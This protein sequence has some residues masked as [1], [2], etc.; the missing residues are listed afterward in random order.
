MTL[1]V[2][3]IKSIFI[4]LLVLSGNTVLHGQCHKLQPLDLDKIQLEEKKRIAQGKLPRYAYPIEVAINPQTHGNWKQ[5]KNGHIEWQF[6]L[7]IPNAIAVNLGIT[8]FF[9]P[10]Q[11]TFNL[12]NPDN[13]SE[14]HTFST[15]DNETHRQLW[16]PNIS[17]NKL[18]LTI[19]LPESERQNLQFS[20]TKVNASFQAIAPAKIAG[21]C[22][23][24]VNCGPVD[25]W[26]IIQPY[27]DVIRSVGRIS[28]NGTTF[29][30]AV[31][32]NNTANDCRPF[33]MTGQHC[34]ISN[35][36]ASSIV[37]NWLYENSNCREIGTI[38]NGQPGDGTLDFIN[39]G[40]IFRAD[41]N[42]ADLTLFELD[43][44]VNP[45]ANTFFAGWNRTAVTPDS[46]CCIHHPQGQE[47]RI[48]FEFDD[49]FPTIWGSGDTLVENGNHILIPNWE[50][51]TTENGSS[52]AP[53][54]NKNQQVIGTLHGGIASCINQEGY[55]KFGRLYAAWNEAETPANSLS[56][57][58]DP[59][60]SNQ[61][62][63]EGK[64]N[65]ACGLYLFTLNNTQSICSQDTAQYSIILSPNFAAEIELSL[66]NLPTNLAA[67]FDTNL[68]NPGDTILLQVFKTGLVTDGKYSM[69]IN[70]TADNT[71]LEYEIELYF[72]NDLP[73][74][75]AT[76]PAHQSINNSI[77]PNF[78]WNSTDGIDSF[79]IEILDDANN[80]LESSIIFNN[81]YTANSLLNANQI[82]HWQVTAYNAC[83]SQLST[84]NS[85]QTSPDLD[86]SF[87]V[88]ELFICK[89]ET[90]IF[91]FQIGVDFFGPIDISVE[92]LPDGTSFHFSDTTI[93][94]GSFNTL[95]IENFEPA[96]YGNYT[97]QLTATDGF[98]NKNQ[99]LLLEILEP[100]LPIQLLFPYNNMQ[101][102]SLQSEFIWESSN[103]GF[104]QITIALDAEFNEVIFS[105]I[106][107]TPLFQPIDFL[108][109]GTVYY[110]S[111]R[112][113]N[114]CGEASS[115]TF[116][117][118]T[119][120]CIPDDMFLIHDGFS[121]NNDGVN[122]TFKINGIHLYPNAE[123]KIYNRWGNQVFERTTDQSEWDGTF[124]GT[125][126]P[127]GS[128][129][130]W[131]GLN[132]SSVFSG[133]VVLRR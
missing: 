57:W 123:L 66:T 127:D 133:V 33:M 50:I 26:D 121:P 96:A 19:N 5:L 6:V 8:N 91:N 46:T 69:L 38:K 62:A 48:S 47:K 89:E 16:T 88:T 117:F 85:F 112:Y 13:K 107:D 11:C 82:Y 18:L 28:I 78:T 25:D 40:A 83:G 23:L 119:K 97:I 93:L 111:V 20:I 125:P 39:T 128:Y 2:I 70:T 44:P 67:N 114:Q 29:C 130:Y 58:L 104:H 27:R 52:G 34:E 75:E 12:I 61:I 71:Q 118:T 9:L 4:L 22:N 113:F 41:I 73:V 37:V 35:I 56:H 116:N 68:A 60:H 76:H 86:F 81:T 17:A 124:K 63:I 84:T 101:A 132:P 21:N 1:N 131:L 120:Q 31:L 109:S 32:I 115:A 80:I 54:F 59:I 7:E 24:D 90:A 98:Q 3:H 102:V 36:N 43:D 77:R 105:E 74:I 94:P 108:T 79:Y 129:F 51:G 64:E 87:D 95:T 55:D 106:L 53:L 15:T 100:P 49:S 14:S 65:T 30:T 99:Q 10:Q 45:L 122:D 92:G 42:E 103:D 72:S 126:V 110:W